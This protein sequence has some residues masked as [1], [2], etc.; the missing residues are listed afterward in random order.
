M[1][2]RGIRG[3]TTVTANDK[4]AIMASTKELLTSILAANQLQT[5]DIASAFFTTTA[6]LNADF[7][8]VAARQMQWDNVPL[9]CGHEMNVP[10]ALPMCLRVLIHVNT[11]KRQEDMV[12]V[13][14]HGAVVLRPDIAGR[15]G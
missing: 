1:Y 10:G 2:C 6:D 4:E 3:A 13:Y 15:N 14:L 7:P 8:A 11:E 9:L 5:A 12:H